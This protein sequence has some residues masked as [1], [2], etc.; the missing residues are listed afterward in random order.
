MASKH[1]LRHSLHVLSQKVDFLAVLVADDVSR[2]GSRISA[3][4]DAV[5]VNYPNDSGSSLGGL[6]YLKSLAD[7]CRISENGHKS[8]LFFLLLFQVME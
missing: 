4:N 5:F 1:D 3:E 8:E 6:W 2:C 7:E